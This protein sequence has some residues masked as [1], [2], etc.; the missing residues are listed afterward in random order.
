MFPFLPFSLKLYLSLLALG[1]G[2]FFG[3][4]LN[5]L[6]Y[7]MVC[8][9]QWSK[10]RSRCPHCSHTLGA[11]D[12]IPVISYCLRR[13]K[14]RYCG[15]KIALRYLVTELALGVCFVSLLWRFGLTLQTLSAAVLCGCLL[16]LSLVDL[17]TQ[18]IPNRF[19]LIPGLLRMGQLALEHKLLSG[20]L[21]GLIFGGGLLL[22][23][24][25]MDKLLG[26]ESLGGGDIKLVA[27]LGLYFSIPECFFLL[28][29]ACCLGLFAAFAQKI[30]AGV[31]FPF[32]PYISV[33]AWLTLLIGSPVTT[34]YRNLF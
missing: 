14:C 12:L 10:G 30:K 29:L 6:A 2:A 22:L 34:W 21:I 13:G 24:L 16:C 33:A 8:N 25:V 19:L 28:I 32:G 7:R 23:T 5:C 26:A 27:L 1:L 11:A 17:D 20:L 15:Q 31:A 3:S 4:S 18:I 9:L